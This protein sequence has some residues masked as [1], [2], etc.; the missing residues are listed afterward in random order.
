M[1]FGLTF[2]ANATPMGP[3]LEN[4]GLMATPMTPDR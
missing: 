2:S 4:G 1:K 3:S